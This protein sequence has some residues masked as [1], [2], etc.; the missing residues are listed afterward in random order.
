MPISEEQ[1]GILAAKRLNLPPTER[2]RLQTFIPN[3][4]NTLALA[5]V[6]DVQKRYWLMTDPA[7]VTATIATDSNGRYY[8]DL[9]TIINAYGV[10]K[11]YLQYG[12]VFWSQTHTFTSGDVHLTPDNYF[13]ITN[14][15]FVTGDA[16]QFTDIAALPSGLVI[17]TTYYVIYLTDGTFQ[18]AE[19]LSDAGAGI[20]IALGSHV[21]GTGH[22]VTYQNT[23]TLS[24]SN[25]AQFANLP[26]A[27][28]IPYLTGYL[29][30]DKLYV[31]GTTSGTL[32]FNVPFVPPTLASLPSFLESDLVDEVV[33]L[34]VT[35]GVEA[36]KT[37]AEK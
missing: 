33:L 4:L 30:A 2:L 10:M 6:N 7:T 26:S 13:A 18:V 27:L 25:Q 23:S 8:A 35:A 15:G 16:I 34:A 20:A 19:S 3:A 5:T 37:E 32:A 28:P 9:S 1:I 29:Q 24:W 31:T 11:D 17:D 14:H 22:M 12:N 21:G 36:P